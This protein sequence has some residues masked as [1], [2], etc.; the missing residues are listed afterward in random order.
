MLFTVLTI[1][2]QLRA[3]YFSLTPVFQPGQLENSMLLHFTAGVLAEMSLRKGVRA[4]V[5][6]V[7]LGSCRTVHA[8]LVTMPCPNLGHL[9]LK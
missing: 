8:L 9:L 2:A 7:L 6:G 4:T 5:P 1:W 3:K